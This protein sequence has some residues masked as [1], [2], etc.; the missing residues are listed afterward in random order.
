MT[1]TFRSLAGLPL[2]ACLLLVGCKQ[3]AEED[4]TK[5][6]NPAV[7]T[8]EH[9]KGP[10]SEAEPTRITLVDEAAKRLG[11]ETGEVTEEGAKGKTQKALPYSAILYDTEGK[12][13]TYTNPEPLVFVRHLIVIDHIDGDRALLTDGPPTGTKV[14]TVGAAE[15]YGSEFEFEEE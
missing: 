4:E 5:V 2:I 11:I 12:V 9:L 3:L 8:V 13:W 14:V 10:E 7:A 1:H 6:E 15:L